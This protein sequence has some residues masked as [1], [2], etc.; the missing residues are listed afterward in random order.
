MCH[1]L[2]LSLVN[3]S[4]LVSDFYFRQKSYQKNYSNDENHL[5][6]AAIEVQ[7]NSDNESKAWLTGNEGES[8]DPLKLNEEAAG[9]EKVA[10]VFK[11]E[12]KEGVENH[13]EAQPDP[14]TQS[15][16]NV[17]RE[18]EFDAKDLLSFAWQIAR[19]MVG[20]RAWEQ[21]TPNIEMRPEFCGIFPEFHSQ[22]VS[23]S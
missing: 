22:S 21:E 8:M 6:L 14:V 15:H 16:E 19:G 23:L 2:I 11:P 9:K 17:Q 20:C 4:P 7:L 10:E 5:Q 12:M 13:Y 18:E 1:P 3:L